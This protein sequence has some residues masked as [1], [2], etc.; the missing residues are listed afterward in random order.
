MILKHR[1]LF[2]LGVLVFT[3]TMTAAGAVS[4]E[5]PAA[6]NE[7]GFFLLPEWHGYNPNDAALME[8]FLK[9]VQS[10]AVKISVPVSEPLKIAIMFPSL[11]TS[12]AWARINISWRRV[13]ILV[14]PI[15]QGVSNA[16]SRA[17]PGERLALA[18]TVVRHWASL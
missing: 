6:A 5:I 11:E 3:I 4:G 2:I 1:S 12:D 17:C 10:P 13:F 14:L 16:T 8:N 9:I 18:P 15:E 7:R